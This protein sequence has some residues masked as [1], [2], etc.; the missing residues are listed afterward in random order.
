MN[1]EALVSFWLFIKILVLA[2][3]EL[4]TREMQNTNI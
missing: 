1:L 2:D 4:E 3:Q